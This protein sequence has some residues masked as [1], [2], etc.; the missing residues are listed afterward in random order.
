M[1]RTGG[2]AAR[3]SLVLLQRDRL[4]SG[5]RDSPCHDCPRRSVMT[6]EALFLVVAFI[7]FVLGTIPIPS[8]INLTSLGTRFLG[9]GDSNWRSGNKGP[10]ARRVNPFSRVCFRSTAEP[11]PPRSGIAAL[12]FLRT[13]DLFQVF[14]KLFYGKLGGVDG[15]R[16]DCHPVQGTGK[17]FS[18]QTFS[19]RPA[20]KKW[21]KSLC[22][23][24]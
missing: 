22:S 9:L 24:S 15:R 8:R 11:Q 6:V 4:F 14:T 21:R 3:D 17:S 2:F 20:A 16:C 12:S 19:V 18:A 1:E 13:G 10:L 23:L 7:C 5:S